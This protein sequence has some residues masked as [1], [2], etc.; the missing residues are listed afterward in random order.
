MKKKLEDAWLKCV[1]CGYTSKLWGDEDEVFAM[2]HL[3]G[4]LS[5]PDCFSPLKIGIIYRQVKE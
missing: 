2:F 4:S 1:N 5:C 3:L